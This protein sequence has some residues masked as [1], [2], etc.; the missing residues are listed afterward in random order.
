M[1]HEELGIG[2]WEDCAGFQAVPVTE[3]GQLLG[4][5]DIKDPKHPRLK[6]PSLAEHGGSTIGKTNS[7]ATVNRVVGWT[8]GKRMLL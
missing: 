2:I 6:V 5:L 4:V 8:A 1:A 7:I 3:K